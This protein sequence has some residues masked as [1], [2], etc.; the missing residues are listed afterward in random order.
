MH[1]YHLCITSINYHLVSTWKW[2]TLQTHNFSGL[3]LDHFL[4]MLHTLKLVRKG[5]LY[6]QSCKEKKQNF[7]AVLLV[8]KKTAHNF[9]LRDLHE[10]CLN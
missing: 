9:V 2:S 1:T 6:E 7:V 10:T 3:L 5:Q 4:E 8:I